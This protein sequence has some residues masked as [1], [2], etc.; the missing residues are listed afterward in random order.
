MPLS[1][2]RLKKDVLIASITRNGNTIIPNGNS[3]IREGDSV[4][5]VTSQ[6][7]FQTIDDIIETGR[8]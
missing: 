6:K 3:V 8:G 5:V 2:I 1:Q 4:V 7:G